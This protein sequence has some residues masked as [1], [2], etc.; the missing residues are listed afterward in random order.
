MTKLKGKNKGGLSQIHM[1]KF[2]LVPIL[3]IDFVLS[4]FSFGILVFDIKLY[5]IRIL[6]P[7]FKRKKRKLSKNR[8][9][10]RK[11]IDGHIPTKKSCY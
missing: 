7:E 1:E 4:T 8:R 5:S 11:W 9:R 3:I 6:V 2:S 10:E